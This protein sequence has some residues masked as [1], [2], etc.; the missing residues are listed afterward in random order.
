MLSA[1]VRI[2]LRFRGIVIAISCL[3]IAYGIYTIFQSKYDVFPEFAPPVVTIQTES[4]GLSPEQVE[5]L[6]TQPVENAIIGVSGIESLR[7]GSIQGLSLITVTFEKGIDIYRARQV[8]AERLSTL[9]GQLPQGV[10]APVMTPLTS[11][12]SVVFAV[13]LTS[14]D[15]SLMD[16]RTIADWTLKPRILA[17]PGVSKVAVLGGEVKQ[18]QVQINPD[19]LIQYNLGI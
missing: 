11:S 5:G 12:T 16:L 17:I 14:R 15:R 4:P 13:G 8:L 10:E 19:R 3:L 9:T 7:S 18:F 1:I 6:V 2:S